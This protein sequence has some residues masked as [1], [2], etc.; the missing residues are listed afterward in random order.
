MT[1]ASDM[2]EIHD[3]AAG[4]LELFVVRFSDIPALADRC[5]MKDNLAAQLL[6]AVGHAVDRIKGASRNRPA[7][8][9]CC[10]RTLTKRKNPFSLVIAVP[11]RFDGTGYVDTAAQKCVALGICERC[12]TEPEDIY[13]KGVEAL[14]RIWPEGHPISIPVHQAGHA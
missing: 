1:W 3:E 5:R 12:A 13:L 4:V 10:P 6:L 7:L 2:Q 9:G 11:A 14:R 8:C